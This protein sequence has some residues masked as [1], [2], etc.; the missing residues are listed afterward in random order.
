MRRLHAVALDEMIDMSMFDEDRLAYCDDNLFTGQLFFTP[1]DAPAGV[2]ARYSGYTDRVEP[3]AFPSPE[4]AQRLA[5]DF[6]LEYAGII[7]ALQSSEHVE[8][9]TVEVGLLVWGENIGS[10]YE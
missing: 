3:V 7:A 6:S 9:A 1:N 5:A 8:S 10:Y 2:V 4:E